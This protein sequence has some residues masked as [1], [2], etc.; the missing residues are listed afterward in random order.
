MRLQFPLL[1]LCAAFAIPAAASRAATPPIPARKAG[2]WEINTQVTA[3]SPM[4]FATVHLCTDA[5]TEAK[6]SAFAARQAPDADCSSGPT[7]RT[8]AGWSFAMTCKMQGMTMTTAGTAS[9][10]FNSNYR[11]ESTTRM[12]PA[13]MPQLAETRTVMT[14]RWLGACPA[15]RKPGDMVMG[16]GMVVNTNR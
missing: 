12:S 10:D 13:P 15:G 2:W 14:S 4:M 3:N 8:A 6:T 7:A 1:A 16:N 5:A 9:G 11:A